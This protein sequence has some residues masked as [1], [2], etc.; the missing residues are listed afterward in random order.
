MTHTATLAALA[1]TGLLA[2]PAALADD[3]PLNHPADTPTGAAHRRWPR[4][5][6]LSTADGR[7]HALTL[8]ITEAIDTVHTLYH[9]LL[10]DGLFVAQPGQKVSP[11]V[12]Y[13]S[14]WMH[15]Y[16][17]I[18]YDN[19]G[20]FRAPGD[21]SN[22]ELVSYSYYKGTNSAGQ[23][24]DQN[25]LAMPP[26]TIPAGTPGGIYR[27]RFVVDWDATEP[28]GSASIADYGGTIADM[29]IYITSTLADASL[30]VETDTATV[31]IFGYDMAPLPAQWP[32]L[33]TLPVN[34]ITHNDAH[35]GSI[36]LTASAPA[37]LASHGNPTQWAMEVDPSILFRGNGVIVPA[38]ILPF[39][40]SLSATAAPGAEEQ[41][42]AA[43][44]YRLI[45]NDEFNAPDGSHPSTELFETPTRYNAAW[46]RFISKQPDLMVMNGGNLQMYCRPNTDPTPEDDRE[47]V[48]G[49]IQTMHKFSFRHGRCEARMR[50][51]GFTG[52][53]P[54]F[55]LMPNTQP[56]GWP[57]SGEID[58]FESINDKDM[59]FATIHTGRKANQDLITHGYQQKTDINEWH[60]YG[61]EWDES[62]LHFSIDGHVYGTL[63][64]QNVNQGLWPFN[65]Q[66]FY[67]ILN[68]S[69]GNGSWA[70][71]PDTSHTYMTE[72]DWVRVYQREGQSST[73]AMDYPADPWAAAGIALPTAD[74][75]DGPVT[76]YN[77]QGMAVNP[78]DAAPGLYIR[79]QGTSATKILIR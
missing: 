43:E 54:A 69:V 49:A 46:N 17:Y 45:W 47:M 70:A 35:V 63:T 68:Q 57:V 67:I 53:F 60:V 74:S 77:L 44:G 3:Y 52:S 62:A 13:S 14:D 59:A 9:D 56:E 23:T 24:V 18:D 7:A 36:T 10:S 73:G 11:S 33:E 34:I 39:P 78:S 50:V 48:S 64:P 27:A 51:H 32:A 21:G 28:G 72:V 26:F 15:A 66:E 42:Y 16:L 61:V 5:V 76:I 29:A 20:Q 4:S 40:T 1:L 25:T 12:D 37:S 79:R 58:I 30:T 38:Y 2:A 19:D 31:R 55:W 6:T 65:E 41:P 75:A 22:G 8:Q 71:N